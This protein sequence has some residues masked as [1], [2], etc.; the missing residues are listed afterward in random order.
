MLGP[1]ALTKSSRRVARIE[2]ERLLDVEHLE[3]GARRSRLCAARASSFLSSFLSELLCL[4]DFFI[5]DRQESMN[6]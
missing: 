6:P 3:Q 4:R 2:R 5:A 1:I